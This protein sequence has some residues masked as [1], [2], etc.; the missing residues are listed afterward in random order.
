MEEL[1]TTYFMEREL[2]LPAYNIKEWNVPI[3]PILLNITSTLGIIFADSM[4]FPK[5]W[6][7][8]N[9]TLEIFSLWNYFFPSLNFVT[10]GQGEFSAV[11]FSW[12]N[13]YQP[14]SCTPY[15]PFHRRS[16][17]VHVLD[18]SI[19]YYP[20]TPETWLFLVISSSNRTIM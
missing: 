5:N 15:D 17:T 3:G 14:I 8:Y 7:L 19:F 20:L 2:T 12:T 6:P 10:A 9:R 18:G 16:F 11:R 1:V 13:R 4:F